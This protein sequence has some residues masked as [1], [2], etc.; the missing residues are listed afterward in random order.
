M[1]SGSTNILAERL[2]NVKR[3]DT[4]TNCI[5]ST[6]DA[7]HTMREF[8][9]AR[10]QPYIDKSTTVLP[11]REQPLLERPL[12]IPHIDIHAPHLDCFHTVPSLQP[13]R[14]PL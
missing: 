9:V 6:P 1:L 4:T 13:N 12:S 3:A 14:P 11:I 7:L 2:Y 8:I 10:L 5:L